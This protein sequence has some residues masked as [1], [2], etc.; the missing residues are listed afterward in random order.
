MRFRLNDNDVVSEVVD[1]EVIAVH[2]QSGTYYSMLETAAWL[3]NALLGG[4][5]E[6]EIADHL[7]QACS[8]EPDRIAGDIARFV[9]T[10][11][12]ENLLMPMAGKTR[13]SSGKLPPPGPYATPKLHKYTDMQEL[14][15][16]DPIHEVTEEGWP[17]RA[18]RER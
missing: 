9:A 6:A 16:V 15:L 17:I 8:G 3:W 11:L 5:S 2:L 1:G 13:A 4:S 12:E 10:L 7:V 18:D 14:L